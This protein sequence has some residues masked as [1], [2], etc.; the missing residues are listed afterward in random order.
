MT[1]DS[2][3]PVDIIYERA[4]KMLCVT[5]ED[6]AHYTLPAELLRVESPSAEVRGHGGARTLVA[7]KADV[8]IE[9]IEPVGR[10]AVR[11]VFSDGHDNGIYSWQTLRGLGEQQEQLW[12]DYLQAL[13]G[14]GL[15]RG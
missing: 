1:P 4:R 12:Q 5:F 9:R 15:S 8:M 6:G 2:V 14:Q 11:L 3:W 7:G 10:Y 13:A